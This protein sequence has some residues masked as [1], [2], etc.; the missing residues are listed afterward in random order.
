MSVKC[1]YCINKKECKECKKNGW[2]DKFIPYEDVKEYFINGYNGVRGYDGKHTWDFNNTNPKL[3]ETHFIL[4]KNKHYCPY[5]GEEM[6]PIQKEVLEFNDYSIT[7]YC[8]IC[9]G[10]RTEIKYEKEKKELEERY[11]KKLES[12]DEKYNKRL[13]F[14]SEKLFK[15]K[16]QKEKESFE[17]YSNKYCHF[18]TLNGDKINDIKQ[19]IR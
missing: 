18:S 7:G 15:I 1:S 14:N 12:L 8:C 13:K 6:F 9:K 11:K 4:I 5:C 19:I 16:Q 3:L 2:F 10:A 17:S